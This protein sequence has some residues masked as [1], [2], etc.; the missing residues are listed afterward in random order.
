MVR[1]L[2]TTIFF[3]SSQLTEMV[4]AAQAMETFLR[5][6]PTDPDKLIRALRIF[7]D[8]GKRSISD[9]IVLWVG[10]GTR[11]QAKKNACDRQR[12]KSPRTRTGIRY[13]VV[14]V[15]F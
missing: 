3:E 5:F 12:G 13:K 1:F 14:E 8:G 4:G 7:I 15:G 11:Y 6:S 2:G 9:A 10:Q